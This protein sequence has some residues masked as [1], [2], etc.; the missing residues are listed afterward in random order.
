L[1]EES[2]EIEA[3][4][5]GRLEFAEVITFCRELKKIMKANT[6][7]IDDN[8]EFEFFEDFLKKPKIFMDQTIEAG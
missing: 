1:F 5:Q 3:N 2:K 7:Y 8:N 4:S 6:P